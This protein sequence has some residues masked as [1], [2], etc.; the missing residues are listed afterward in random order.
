MTVIEPVGIAPLGP[1]DAHLAAGERAGVDGLVEGD[2]RLETLAFV[3]PDGVTV[4]TT[5][6]VVSGVSWNVIDDAGAERVAREVGDRRGE[7]QGVGTPLVSGAEK[8]TT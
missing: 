1:A 7:L 3:G 8:V 5:G 6:G 2:V 4:E